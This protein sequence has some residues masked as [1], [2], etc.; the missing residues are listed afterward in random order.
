[1]CEAAIFQLRR[2]SI[3]PFRSTTRA[4]PKLALCVYSDSPVTC[5]KSVCICCVRLCSQRESIHVIPPNDTRKQCHVDPAVHQQITCVMFRPTDI[6][7]LSQTRREIPIP[8]PR[9]ATGRSCTLMLRL[10]E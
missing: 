4:V 9:T 10:S 6:A 1:M 7:P 8:S 3:V 2:A 5:V